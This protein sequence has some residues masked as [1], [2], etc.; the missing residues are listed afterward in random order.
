MGMGL[1]FGALAGAGG[2][3]AD[4]A[5][6]D[7]DSTNEEKRARM[8]ADLEE[9]KILRIEEARALR[10]RQAGIAQGSQISSEAKRLLGE[11]DA[12]ALNAKFGTSAT[13]EDAAVLAANPEARKAYGLPAVDRLGSLETRATAAEN[14]GYLEASKEARGLIQTE[15]TNLR[16]EANDKATNRRLDMAEANSARSAARQ[17][18]LAAAQIAH[19]KSQAAYQ[20]NRDELQDKKEA[21]LATYNALNGANQDIKSIEKQLSDPMIDEKLKGILSIQLST[22]RDEA[23]RLRVALAGAGLGGSAVPEPKTGFD[24]SKYPIGG[25]PAPSAS[26]GE[27]VEIASRG[28]PITNSK[29]SSPDKPD[30]KISAIANALGMSNDTAMNSIVRQKAE[31]IYDLSNKYEDAQKK[32]VAAARGGNAAKIDAELLRVNEIKRQLN[33]VLPENMQRDARERVLSVAGI[34]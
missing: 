21:R 12:A 30:I 31:T 20:S 8:L 32:Y 25:K 19:M 7:Q 6:R 5:K 27:G 10:Q 15:I 17:E 29:Q 26:M 33:V 2:A 13:A 9:Q 4:I 11:S 23:K 24:P 34:Y 16:N 18:A 28:Q 3:V 14:L 22:T 1:L